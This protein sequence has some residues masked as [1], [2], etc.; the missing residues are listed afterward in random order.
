MATAKKH[1]AAT[2]AGEDDER[3]TAV[4]L[5]DFAWETL[6]PMVIHPIRVA[7]IEVMIRLETPVSA[8]DVQLMLEEPEDQSVSVVSYHMR[9]LAEFG[10]IEET[11]SRS[12]RGA[13]QT[14]Y[15]LSPGMT[16]GTDGSSR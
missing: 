4:L 1:K 14:F 11:G 10:A 8:R 3:G 16:T 13:N 12:V 15:F 6:V 7:I 2:S 9:C 5:G